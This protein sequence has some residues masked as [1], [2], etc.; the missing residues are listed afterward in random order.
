MKEN[1]QEGRI[2]RRRTVKMEGSKE[3]ELERLEGLREEEL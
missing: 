3:R 1:C 2:K